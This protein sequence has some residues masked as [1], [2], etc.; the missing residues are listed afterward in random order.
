MRVPFLDV[1]AG[2]RELAPAINAA[3]QGCLERG[4]YIGG[5]EVV[6]FETAFASYTGAAHCV[7]V[8]NGLDALTLT[9]RALDIGPGDEVIVPAHTFIATWLAVSQVGATPIPVDAQESGFN[10]DVEQIEAAITE[11]TRAIMPVHLYGE[12]APMQAIMQ[13]AAQHDL[14]VIEDAAQAHGA[15]AQGQAIGNF[16]VA[17]CWSF[18]PAKNLGAAGDGGAVTTSDPALAQRVRELANYGSRAKYSHERLGVNSRLDPLQAAVLSVK[19]EVLDQWNQR[20]RHVA[21]RYLEE[22]ADSSLVLPK[23]VDIDDSAWHLFVVEHENRDA[24]R[25]RLQRAGVETGVHYPRPPHKQK[26]YA[27][28]TVRAV[29]DRAEALSRRVVSLPIG[30]HLSADAVSTTIAACCAE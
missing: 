2:Y 27:Q 5:G 29:L 17:A 1:A 23:V 11:R 15:R 4:F 18:Y 21:R 16:G 3:V 9:L 28:L 8:G 20:R 25:Q 19:L 22:L 24:L 30:P 6:A 7:G 10:I 12:P 14:R 13:L 26:A